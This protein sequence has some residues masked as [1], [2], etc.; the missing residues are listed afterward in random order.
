[1]T[2]PVTRD[3]RCWK[4]ECPPVPFNLQGCPWPTPFSNFKKVNSLFEKKKKKHSTFSC[5]TLGL[6]PRTFTIIDADL[7]I[8]NA[9]CVRSIVGS[10]S[11]LGNLLCEN[12]IHPGSEIP[13]YQ[14]H[15][16]HEKYCLDSLKYLNL[17]NTNA[18]RI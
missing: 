8:S 17:G 14:Y 5:C 18:V 2:S 1:M 15:D 12:Q 3:N 16:C 10:I 6:E 4:G 9:E 11:F 7:L 13:C